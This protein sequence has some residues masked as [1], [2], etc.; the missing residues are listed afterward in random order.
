MQPPN[1]F[2]TS[3]R[4]ALRRF[5]RS[6]LTMAIFTSP[7]LGG[8][9]YY[10]GSIFTSWATPYSQS[11]S[12]S[13]FVTVDETLINN[14]GLYDYTHHSVW[15]FTDG[16]QTLSNSNSGPQSF[17]ALAETAGVISNWDLR[18][19]NTAF[20][21]PNA[22]IVTDHEAGYVESDFGVYP[23]SS[24]STAARGV[25]STSAPNVPEPSTWA[26]ITF[27]ITFLVGVGR[28]RKIH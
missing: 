7:M 11:D 17:V 4:T 24:G 2:K 22:R 8:T 3:A 13:G 15:S 19:V 12:I 10:Q 21:F 1:V 18:F 5:G 20:P 6:L 9:F 25:W 26:T 28:L 16:V 27:G 14:S 23:S